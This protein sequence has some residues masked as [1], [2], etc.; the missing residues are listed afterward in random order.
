MQSLLFFHQQTD[1][2]SLR[3]RLGAFF[4]KIRDKQRLDPTSQFV[5]AFIGSRTYGEISAHAFRCLSG[6]Y[7]SWDDIANVPTG[8]IEAALTGIAFSEKKA[9]DLQ[10]ALRKIRARAGSI[11]LEFLA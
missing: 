9:P 1:L 5:Y 3:D 11:N 6:R 4:G 8:D 10:H 7:R 2:Q